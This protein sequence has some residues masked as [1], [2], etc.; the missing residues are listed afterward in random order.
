MMFVKCKQ[1]ITQFPEVILIISRCFLHDIYFP[2]MI[3]INP[4]TEFSMNF[5]IQGQSNKYLKTRNVNNRIQIVE[6]HVVVE[7]Y[8]DDLVGLWRIW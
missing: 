7:Y 3:C 1:T 2:N 6:G 4:I 5:V 8:G